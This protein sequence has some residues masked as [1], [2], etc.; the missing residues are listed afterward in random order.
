MSQLYLINNTCSDY[1]DICSSH[2]VPTAE[3]NP[4]WSLHSVFDQP[5]SLWVR[6]A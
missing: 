3:V 4:V 6:P 1:E 2:D 5:L